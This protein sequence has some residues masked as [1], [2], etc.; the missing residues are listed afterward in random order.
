MR[1][2]KRKGFEWQN[3]NGVLSKTKRNSSVC[4][5][6]TK[7]AIKRPTAFDLDAQRPQRLKQKKEQNK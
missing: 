1:S 4:P 7:C 2:T 6:I 5:L 3:H